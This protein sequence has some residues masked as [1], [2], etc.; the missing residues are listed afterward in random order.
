MIKFSIA[1]EFEEYLDKMA[2]TNTPIYY[3]SELKPTKRNFN[4]SYGVILEAAK[5]KYAEKIAISRESSN[6]LNMLACMDV[7]HCSIQVY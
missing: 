4:P 3:G 2:S 6:S 1:N 7:Q 5:A